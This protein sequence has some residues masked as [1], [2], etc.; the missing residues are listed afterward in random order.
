MN[1][2]NSFNEWFEDN[3][4]FLNANSISKD[5]AQIIWNS[6]KASAMHDVI[7]MVEDG[8]LRV[9]FDEIL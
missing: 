6:A 9:S 1:D 3:H 5:I 2:Q 4:V 7:T 8:K